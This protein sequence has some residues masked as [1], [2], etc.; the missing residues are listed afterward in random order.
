MVHSP[1]KPVLAIFGA[2][3]LSYIWTHPPTPEYYT[4]GFEGLKIPQNLN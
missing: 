1:F 4:E 2:G 3:F